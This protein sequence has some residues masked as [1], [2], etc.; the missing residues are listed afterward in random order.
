MVLGITGLH[1]F[2]V[3]RSVRSDGEFSQLLSWSGHGVGHT[4]KAYKLRE[5]EGSR[6]FCL[7]EFDEQLEKEA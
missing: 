7:K 2:A 1:S 3:L 4:K 6:G 5:V